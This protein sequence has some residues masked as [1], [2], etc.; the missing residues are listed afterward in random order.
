M[1]NRR[2]FMTKVLGGTA[3]LAAANIYPS[4]R[5][6]GANDRVRFG[7]IGCGG[8]GLA[9]F[10]AALRSPNAEAVAVADVYTR[11]LDEAKKLAPRVKTYAD[12]RRLLDDK[13]IDAVL[14]A[15]PQHQHALQFVPAIQAGKD[16]YQ[17]KTMAFNPD[18][19]RRMR[20][21]FEGSNRI[22][23]IGSQA[24]SGPAVAAAREYLNDAH[25]GTITQVHT[26]HYRNALFGGWKRPIPADCDTQH[27]DW[28]MFQGEAAPHDFDANR[29]MNWRFYWDYSGG[30]VFENMVHQVVFWYKMLD[31]KIPKSVTMGGGN[32]M[33]PEM[34]VPDTYDVS[35]DQ[36]TLLFTWNSMFG[37][38]HY[39]E[40]DDAVLGT[41]GT[42]QRSDREHIQYTP[43]S[44]RRRKGAA[45]VAA[46][47]A[48][49]SPDIVGSSGMTDRHMQNFFDCVRS[50][51]EPNCPFELGFRS[52]IA[53]RMALVSYREG[54]RVTWDAER[55]EIV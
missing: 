35:M 52:A 49:A 46:E 2:E 19:A 53:C 42:I 20:R 48:A 17:E 38:K 43:E 14:I 8:R 16:V 18:H 9:D 1:S 10:R 55:E 11:R 47:P 31:L 6:L 23:Q 32:Y 39:G 4:S 12:F 50:R 37:N 30:N 33:N 28:K 36:G 45:D 7:L 24:T 51:K 41:K 54:R 15:T 21:A 40:G 5:A 27:I 22:V 29:Y 13:T 34:E 26:H 25:M 44:G 3:G